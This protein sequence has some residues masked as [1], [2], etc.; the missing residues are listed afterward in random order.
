MSAY[1]Q[2]ILFKKKGDL[3]IKQ[4]DIDKAI[5]Y[6]VYA[7]E[8]LR[9]Y[10]RFAPDTLKAYIQKAID[11]LQEA[12]MEIRVKA[13]RARRSRKV[14]PIERRRSA[15]P[16]PRR[17]ARRAIEGT[18]A[19]S[20]VLD[21]QEAPIPRSMGVPEEEIP[22]ECPQEIVVPER[23]P[24]TFKDLA[25]LEEV[26]RDLVESIEW[27]IKYP[28]K[29]KKLGIK[30]ISGVLLFGPPGCGKTF[31]V[32]CAAGEFGL[33]LLSASPGAIL[34]KYVGESEKLVGH[35]FRCAAAMSPSII[36][37]DEVDK[38]LPAQTTSSDA[39]KRV[40]AQFLQEMDGVASGSGF[41]VI[42][43]TNEPWNI[44]PALIRPGRVDRI[45]YVPPPDKAVRRKLFELYL[46]NITMDGVSIDDLVKA[47][48]PDKTGYYSSSGIKA[49]CDDMKR[50]IFRRWVEKNEEVPLTKDIVKDA[51]RRVRRSITHDQ[52][53]SYTDWAKKFASYQ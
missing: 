35:M 45:I 29:L 11:N 34:S 21:T 14:S 5:E 49:L 42:M 46:K 9:E 19:M 1:D 2:A 4:G 3:Y 27:P 8:K 30:P 48:E 37:V 31:L 39:P 7:I 41:I 52:I 36:F 15:P 53:K 50:T 23:P 22:A 43:A 18:K 24:Y 28:E 6:Y 51:L 13:K 17:Q 25:G 40:E 12:V 44:N 10:Q 32:K 33:M 20:D 38:L 16:V 47:T 26:K